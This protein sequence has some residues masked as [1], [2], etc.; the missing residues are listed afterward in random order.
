MTKEK[1]GRPKME[2][3]Y[4]KLDALLQFKVTQRFCAD[5]LE[6]SEDTIGRRL[7]D[8]H[9]MTFSEYHSLKMERTS[10]KL[11]QKAIEQAFAGNSTMMIF[12]LKNL[13]KWTDKHETTVNA[14]I[15]ITIDNDDSNL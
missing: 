10:L 2:L 15:G 1:T 14:S 12:A 8:D 13:A 3:N 4:D 7:K 5:Y 6:C 11:Q 9:D